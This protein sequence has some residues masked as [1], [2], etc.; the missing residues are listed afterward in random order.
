MNKRWKKLVCVLLICVVSLSKKHTV[1][2]ENRVTIVVQE[3]DVKEDGNLTIEIY[4]KN[5]KNLGGLDFSLIYDSKKLSY[6][7]S[8]LQGNFAKGFGETNHISKESMVRIVS[9]YQ[10]PVEEDGKVATITFNPKTEEIDLPKLQVND[11]VDASLE[12]KNIPF[13][14]QYQKREMELTTKEPEP[15]SGKETIETQGKENGTIENTN[16]N[17]KGDKER[18]ESSTVKNESTEK[19]NE[20]GVGQINEQQQIKQEEGSEIS[21][22]ENVENTGGEEETEETTENSIENVKMKSTDVRMFAIFSVIIGT[23]IGVYI[24]KKM[25]KG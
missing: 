22:S 13:E 25:K 7:N 24:I 1:L 18:T 12:I 8:E 16:G 21:E 6:I 14:V 5:L 9:I 2:A 15:E 4:L 11:L 3:T 20:N 19:V 23:F 17:E 10:S